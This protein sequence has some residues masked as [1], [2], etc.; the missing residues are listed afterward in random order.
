MVS[1]FEK[2]E[3]KR[4]DEN[5]NCCIWYEFS[6]RTSSTKREILKSM[7]SMIINNIVDEQFRED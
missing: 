2:I 1:S 5:W 7:S 3:M 4:K 6:S